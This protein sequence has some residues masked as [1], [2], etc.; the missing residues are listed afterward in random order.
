[1]ELDTARLLSGHPTGSPLPEID[2]RALQPGYW[3]LYNDHLTAGLSPWGITYARNLTPHGT[4]IKGWSENVFIKALRTG[5]YM[6]MKEWRG[7]D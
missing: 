7:H 4:G 2:L 1:M 5:K 3:T 6:G